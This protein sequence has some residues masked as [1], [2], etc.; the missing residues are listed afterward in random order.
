[1]AATTIT[2]TG[3]TLTNDTGS[4]S[5]PAG[6][7]T[8]LNASWCST[9]L[10]RIDAL[11]SGNVTF[12]GTVTVE[13]T[14]SAIV[15]SGTSSTNNTIAVTNTSAGASAYAQVKV[16]NGVGVALSLAGLSSGYS[17]ISGYHV[18][19]AGHVE[20]QLAGGL[21]LA[22]YHAQGDIRFFSGGTTERARFASS[23]HLILKELSTNPSTTDLPS[24]AAIAVYTKADKLVFAYNNGGTMTYIYLDLDGSDTGWYHGLTA[25]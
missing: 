8:L 4:A 3:V 5:S 15:V 11:F 1:M 14:G 21:S 13:G 24:A 19:S 22:A 2:R 17:G 7:G 16:S 9:F 10:D 12:G 20:A 6:D 18:A 25:P 23:G